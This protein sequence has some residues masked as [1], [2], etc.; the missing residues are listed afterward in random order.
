MALEVGNVIRDLVGAL[1]GRP[2]EARR[3]LS[4][5]EAG[6]PEQER[7]SKRDAAVLALREGMAEHTKR[8][9]PLQKARADVDA[10][11]AEMVRGLELLGA[12]RTAAHRAVEGESN[13][14]SVARSEAERTLNATRPV[15]LIE[16][17][18]DVADAIRRA[19]G[20]RQEQRI[21]EGAV[22]GPPYLTPPSVRR[23][24]TNERTAA[25]RHAAL[26]ALAA[27]CGALVLE[28][29]ATI[30]ERVPKFRGRLSTLIAQSPALEPEDGPQAA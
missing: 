16:L 25:E 3:I 11:L 1:K 2:A 5:L 24:Y 4:A 15:A 6:L 12:E 9:E 18:E 17:Q 13:R 20:A 28:S 23:W 19:T 21:E 10:R 29:E 8:I 27:E 26:L 30:S 22:G 7:I 14:F